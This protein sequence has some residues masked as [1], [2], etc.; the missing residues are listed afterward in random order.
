MKNIFLTGKPGCGKTSL[1]KEI[2]FRLKDTKAEGFFTSEIREKGERKG[3]KIT[4]LSGKEAVMAHVDFESPFKVSK[5]KVSVENLEKIG[6]GSLNKAIQEADLIVIDE[7]GKMELFSERIKQ[8]ILDALESPKRVLGTITQSD[9][10]FANEIK[11][12]KDTL[13][14]EVTRENREELVNRIVKLIYG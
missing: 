5:Y 1:I 12:R 4:S 8:A 6:L 9:I 7:I 11:R 2:I 13:I 3:F 14:L 10:K